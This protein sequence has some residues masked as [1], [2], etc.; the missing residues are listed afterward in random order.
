MAVFRVQLKQG[1]RTIV[2]HIEAKNYQNVLNFYNS[3]ST[4]KVSEILE[5][6][7]SDKTIPPIDDFNYKKLYKGFIRNNDTHISR[8][9]IIHNIK[10]S[11]SENDIS[12][13]IKQYLSIDNKKIDSVLVSLFKV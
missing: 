13:Y 1:S 5:V 10:K 8:Q 11:I 4:M 12:N 7:Y 2:E 6:K 9:V 3:V